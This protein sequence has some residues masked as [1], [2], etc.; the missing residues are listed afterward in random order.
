MRLNLESERERLRQSGY[1]DRE[2]WER[3]RDLGINE[4]G[5]YERSAAR[6]G[7][8]E[9]I[10]EWISYGSDKAVDLISGLTGPAGTRV[11]DLYTASKYFLGQAVGDMLPG[12]EGITKERI[13]LGVRDAV[14]EVGWSKAADH[15]IPKVAKIPEGYDISGAT[16]YWPTGTGAGW[17]WAKTIRGSAYA[18]AIKGAIESTFWDFV[19]ND[20]IKSDFKGDP[21]NKATNAAEK[22]LL[23][24]PD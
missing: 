22:Y 5:I 24:M 8:P 18:E 11:K 4:Y 7:R 13:G 6:M 2:I 23:N 3:Q 20:R 19:A 21:T 10:G 12:G 9:F 1:S 17:L 15:L 16:S 14:I